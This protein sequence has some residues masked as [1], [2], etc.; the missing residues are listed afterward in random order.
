MDETF[1]LITAAKENDIDR[2]KTLIE[3]GADV[4]AK[5]KQGNTAL[6]FAKSRISI[7]S[8]KILIQSGAD[9]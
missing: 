6:M 2:L 7:D 9:D 1:E 5:D 8:L 3:N 4:N